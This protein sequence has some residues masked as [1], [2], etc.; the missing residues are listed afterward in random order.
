MNIKAI[1]CFAVLLGF[2]SRVI[3]STNVTLVS[4][5]TNSASFSVSTGQVAKV[6]YTSIISG[7]GSYLSI[8]VQGQGI[9]YNSAPTVSPVVVGPATITL[10]GGAGANLCTLELSTPT[11]SVLP[12][13]AIVIPADSGGPVNII[14][15][16]SADLINWYP[17][18]PGTYGAN[19]TNRFF[20]VRAQRAP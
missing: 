18:L 11:D 12:S 5:G 1:I 9:Y 3:G 2:H 4:I 17:S 20:R 13:N 6:I 7:S 10:S 15:E 16:S 19:Y 14:L 8:N